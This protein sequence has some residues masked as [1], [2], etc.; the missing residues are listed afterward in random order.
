MALT[1]GKKLR[2]ISQMNVIKHKIDDTVFEM[3]IGIILFAVVCELAGVC[4]AH[5][6]L[7]LT[8]GIALGAALSCFGTWHIWHMLDSS[9]GSGDE[10]GV[11]K[12][13]GTGYLIRY[14]ALIVLVAVLYLTKL[15]DPFAAF[16]AYLGM[17]PA[18]YLQPRLHR[19]LHRHD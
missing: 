14:L 15:G 5:D 7:G 18:A 2:K 1:H 11:S 8:V 17:K 19:F 16:I 9:L 10:K 3:W 4:F 12:R 6:R 13:I